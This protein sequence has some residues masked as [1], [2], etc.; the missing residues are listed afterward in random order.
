MPS[1]TESPEE[2]PSQTAESSEDADPDED[3]RTADEH[4]PTPDEVG[5]ETPSDSEDEHEE[6]DDSDESSEPELRMAQMNSTPIRRGSI[7]EHYKFHSRPSASNSEHLIMVQVGDGTADVEDVTLH[8]VDRSGNRAARASDS[9]WDYCTSNARG[10]C[11]FIIPEARCLQ[12]SGTRCV[13]SER[14]Y[15]R[16]LYVQAVD[17]AAGSPEEVEPLLTAAISPVAGEEPRNASRYRHRVGHRDGTNFLVRGTYESHSGR[18]FMNYGASSTTPTGSLGTFPVSRPNPSMPDRCGLDVAVTLDFS[19]SMDG[20]ERALADATTAFVDSLEGTPSSM[21]LFNFGTDSPV[22]SSL[23]DL[24]GFNFAQPESVSTSAGAQTVRGWYTDGQ[25]NPNFNIPHGQHAQGQGTNWHRGFEHPASQPYDYDV[26]VFVTDG[27]P[28]LHG[29][30]PNTAGQ[31]GATTRYQDIE[32][33]IFAANSLKAQGTQVLAVGAG[34]TGIEH[35]YSTYNLRAISGPVEEQ[36]YFQTPEFSAAG[37]YLANM[38]LESCTPTV[39]VVKHEVPEGGGA[40]DATPGEGWEFSAEITGDDLVRWEGTNTQRTQGMTGV[41][42]AINF[43]LDFTP[44]DQAVVDLTFTETWKDGWEPYP[45]NDGVSAVCRDMKDG[46]NILDVEVND[47]QFTIRDVTLDMA[48]TCEFWNTQQSTAA[49][50]QV[51]KQWVIDGEVIPQGQQPSDYD[52]DLLITRPSDHSELINR[53]WGR[54][55]AGYSA[56]DELTLDESLSVNEELSRCT[57]EGRVTEGRGVTNVGDL[58]AGPTG[59]ELPYETAALEVGSGN[60]YTIT[61]WVTCQDPQLTLEKH[62]E[63]GPGGDAWRLQAR[64][65][66]GTLVMD[67]TT[68]EATVNSPG[69]VTGEVAPGIYHLAESAGSPLYVQLDDRENPEAFPHATG[70]WECSLENR[71]GERIALPDTFENDGSNGGVSVREGTHVVC[72]AVNQTAQLTLLKT[73]EGEGAE[74]SPEDFDLTATPDELNGDF[75]GELTENIVPG[76]SEVDEAQSF[77]VRPDHN[78]TLSEVLSERAAGNLAYVQLGLQ[79]RVDGEWVDVDTDT[80]TVGANDHG[81]YRFV[82]REAPTTDLPHTGGTGT[83]PYLIAGAALM[84]LALMT[85]AIATLRRRR[86]AQEV[87]SDETSL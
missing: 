58:L 36:D 41:D 73:I 11:W 37:Q 26:L 52:A 68:G 35:D 5:E 21:A 23:P 14:N 63:S 8:L 43:A 54:R 33:A 66:D 24:P 74:L 87:A 29:R 32:Q 22:S 48:I 67:G 65:G 9:N 81:I 4:A 46:E 83:S 2:T 78:Y 31:L 30:N 50:V 19:S 72:G 39:T 25:G 84:L 16:E 61:N 47:D 62:I 85:A 76:V 38:I 79:Q 53:D 75:A 44:N 12:A 70:S 42:G 57:V 1:P 6:G 51:D 10:E 60:R 82:N 7:P 27:N 40:N 20:D 18:D 17:D 86:L 55:L 15:D 34:E 13:Q 69:S 49:A 56:G 77:Y 3:E 28:T 80:I 64:T 45:I 71:Q 59:E